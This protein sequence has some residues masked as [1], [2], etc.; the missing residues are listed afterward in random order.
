MV[1]FVRRMWREIAEIIILREDS[2]AR[3]E[4]FCA[5][6]CEKSEGGTFLTTS[7]SFDQARDAIGVGRSKGSHRQIVLCTLEGNIKRKLTLDVDH[8]AKTSTPDRIVY[9]WNKRLSQYTADYLVAIIRKKFRSSSVVV[10][11]A[12]E[13][14]GLSEKHPDPLQN[15]YH[16]ELAS[17]TKV[18]GSSGAETKGLS[19]ALAAFGSED[20]MKL[21]S[22]VSMAALLSIIKSKPG[23]GLP[24]I[25]GELSQQLQLPKRLN[26]EYM[27]TIATEI[28]NEDLIEKKGNGWVLTS[29]GE[30][31]IGNLTTNAADQL[32]AGRVLIRQKLE[33]SIGRKL[34]DKHY[35]TMWSSLQDCFAEL[36]YSNGLA[37]ICAVNEILLG[38]ESDPSSKVN[39]MKLVSDGAKRVG[40][41]T[42][43]PET[44][45]ELQRAVLDIFTERTGEA[46]DWLARVA[47]RF[48]ALCSLG[49]EATSA[50]EVRKILLR[51]QL[52]LDTDIVLTYL[53]DGEPDHEAAVELLNRWLE[54]K[55]EVMVAPTI[56][57]EVANHAWI[58]DRH[59]EPTVHLLGKLQEKDLPYYTDNAFVRAFHAHA[60]SS[61]DKAKWPKFIEQYRGNTKEDYSNI[62]EILS[63]ELRMTTLS[64]KFDTNLAGQILK[65]LGEQLQ[66]MKSRKHPHE[67]LTSEDMGKAK[68][69]GELLATIAAARELN[70]RA[71]VEKTVVVISSSGRLRQAYQQF[72]P[73][74][75]NP[76]A[77]LSLSALSYLLSM[78]PENPLGA[79]SLRRALFDV[80]MKA[81]SSEAQQLAMQIIKSAGTFEV[82][83]ARRVTLR[84]AL[85]RSIRDHAERLG[86]KPG[87]VEKQFVMHQ[88]GVPYSE[89][90][91][92]AVKQMAVP[93]P[94]IARRDARI[95]ELE[96]RIDELE[97]EAAAQ[98]TR[99][100]LN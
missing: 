65:Y 93:A 80:T 68:R 16:A 70:K 67:G 62:A 60:E 31:R 48:V 2:P 79:G 57:Q 74:L 39:L 11:G 14:A 90:I 19:L 54:I 40:Q 18:A 20:A 59:F 13:L 96:H 88:R 92:A 86:K 94:E 23:L 58:A 43:N 17:I 8:L 49:L 7:R 95:R 30:R 41:T 26:L 78:L 22:E 32:L 52:S 28:V 29:C 21:R 50:E 46:F 69:D 64:E 91:G 63:D 1:T 3:F 97:A 33:T 87:V 71:N 38:S 44:R 61:K 27:E 100:K 6:L 25:A 35:E 99:Q 45:D 36:F 85:E 56:L 5:E 4:K 81:G 98:K 47:E 82:P 24:E 84:R 53:C 76:D 77:V 55:G 66:R 9:C 10:Y 51:Y 12:E 73:K 37:T 15:Y 83:S 72:R 34:D 42:Q 89:I 75:G